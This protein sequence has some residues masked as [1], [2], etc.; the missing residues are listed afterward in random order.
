MFGS[1]TNW[2]D[3]RM[4]S[5]LHDRM[6][7]VSQG[8]SPTKEGTFQE[9]ENSRAGYEKTLSD[10]GGGEMKQES[11]PIRG[12][13]GGGLQQKSDPAKGQ[14]CTTF[15]KLNAQARGESFV[16]KPSSWPFQVKVTKMNP[17]VHDKARD[18]LISHLRAF[19]VEYSDF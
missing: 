19:E 7:T 12:Q 10:G 3:H 5:E 13:L 8:N 2:T 15:D 17:S 18:D 14:P 9:H 11:G 16:N 4:Q 1:K 6:R